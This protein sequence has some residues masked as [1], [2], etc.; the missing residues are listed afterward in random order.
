[1]KSKHRTESQSNRIN[2]SIYVSVSK[3]K[4]LSASELVGGFDD[5]DAFIWN[6]QLGIGF[7]ADG[8]LATGAV[9]PAKSVVLW[10]TRYVD[11]HRKKLCMW[12]CSVGVQHFVQL[13]QRPKQPKM[14]MS[15]GTL[16]LTW[17]LWF[18]L[19]V[20]CHILKLVVPSPSPILLVNLPFDD[21]SMIP[22][23]H[24]FPLPPC[25]LGSPASRARHQLPRCIA[26]LPWVP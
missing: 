6:H 10:P 8:M 13:W 18:H 2:I 3:S 23:A 20:S 26:S 11:T 24:N 25:L 1:M 22:F 16:P 19:P 21:A 4:S 14:V 12:G 17:Y 5:D 15:S 9:G 7:W